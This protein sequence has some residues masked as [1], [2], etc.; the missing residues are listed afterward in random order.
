MI[1]DP[2]GNSHVENLNAPLVDPELHTNHY[3]RNKEQD[4]LIGIYEEEL[5]EIA[6][7][8]EEEGSSYLTYSLRI[9]HLLRKFF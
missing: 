6:E 4:H 5:K 1:D 3:V 2:S 9:T 7:E 8:N